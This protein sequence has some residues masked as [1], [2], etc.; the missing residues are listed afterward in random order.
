MELVQRF[1][2]QCLRA[3]PGVSDPVQFAGGGGDAF[4]QVCWRMCGGLNVVGTVGLLGS[5]GG[6]GLCVLYQLLVGRGG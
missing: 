3:M 4:L 2:A 1:L 6:A 5:R